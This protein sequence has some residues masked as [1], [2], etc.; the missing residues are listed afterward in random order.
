MGEGVFIEILLVLAAATAVAALF[1]KLRLP[2]IMGFLLAGSMI[3]PY[4]MR[5]LPDLARIDAMAN[6][7][8]IF[9]MLTIGMEF[10]F[11]KLH[12]MKRVAVF[13]GTLQLVLSIAVAMVL[14]QAL[15]WAPFKSFV[16]GCV[17]AQ[18]STA[19]VFKYLLDRAE[20]DTQH[21]R[22]SFAILIVQDMF[23]APILILIA[24]LGASQGLDVASIGSSM[25][26]AVLFVGIIL[27]S[28]RFVLPW[29]SRSIA[30]SRS[31]E[32]FLL[33]AIILCFGMSVL[34][35][36]LGFSMALGAFFAGVLLAN[37]DYVHQ[38]SGEIA[39]F[40]H[41]FV[42]IFFVSIGLLFDIGFTLTHLPVVLGVVASILIINILVNASIVM[43]FGYSPRVALTVG[44][45]LSQ[46][47]EFSF[48][49]LQEA[50][51]AA[52]I[53]PFVYQVILSSTVITIL[54]TPLFFRAV[55]YLTRMSSHIP[56][57]GMPPSAA[58][59]PEAQKGHVILC[60]YGKAGQDLALALTEERAPLTI[61]EMNPS[62]VRQARKEGYTVYYGDASNRE[63]LRK[64][65]IDR[66][67]AL[68]VSFGDS[69]SLPTIV[70]NAQSL[71]P[72]VFLI[73]RTRFEKN[74]PQL[75][76][77]GAD[78]VVMEE[79]EASIDLTRAMLD[80][81]GVGPERT[82]IHTDRIRARKE[83][84]IEQAILRQIK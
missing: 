29:V 41:V 71:N 62:H 12:G 55:P 37:T 84:L 43:F 74:V 13:G 54:L 50:R 77:L 24:A 57:L 10:S 59:L 11:E 18:S 69:T 39:P 23:V 6:V 33:S 17:I 61:L 9:L 5:I 73:V 68:V 58:P 22:I 66:A 15:G 1:E 34:S 83:L 72:E 60:G 80:H 28:A 2:T 7:G 21:G 26:K 48:L 27:L 38:I 40:R 49:I 76:E 16:L 65:G 19:V 53:D 31:R 36:Q 64:I 51:K 45:I 47:G 35:H 25:I 81:L 32:V 3:G 70:K 79:L 56:F 82:K 67:S 44:L 42:S 52:P 46:I 4:G 30:G 63:V 20:L 75:Y 8:M 78:V 14:G